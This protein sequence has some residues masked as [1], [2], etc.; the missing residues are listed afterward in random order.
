MDDV[1]LHTSEN[2]RHHYREEDCIEK[3][4][5]DLKNKSIKVINYEKK[6]MIVLTDEEI[7][8]Y[9]KQ[10]VRYIHKKEF[11]TDEND[12]SKFKLKQKVRGYCHYTEKFRGT[13]HNICK[14]VI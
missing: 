3:F 2:K 10:K 9:K 1:Q 6:K 14:F 7:N 4:C 11:F 5:K 8:S 13:A 12:K